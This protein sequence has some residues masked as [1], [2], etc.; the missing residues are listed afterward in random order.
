[1]KIDDLDHAYELSQR[2]LTAQKMVAHLDAISNAEVVS[3][4]VGNENVQIT[5]KITVGPLLTCFK[6]QVQDVTAS[7]KNY[8][9]VL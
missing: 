2:L 6:H 3:V 1:M 8:G 7:L 9:V 4:T 5:G